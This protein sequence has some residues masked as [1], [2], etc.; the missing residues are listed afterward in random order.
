MK[1]YKRLIEEY[2]EECTASAGEEKSA[3]VSRP[4]TLTGLALALGFNSRSELLEFRGSKRDTELIENAKLRIENFN[5]EKLFEKDYARS[6]IFNLTNSYA[7]SETPEE[8]IAPTKIPAELIAAPFVDLYRDILAQGHMEYVLKGGRGSTK[9]SFAALVV[10]ERLMKNREEHAIAMRQVGATLKDS[11]YARLCWA[12]SA[13]GL[14]NEFEC[15]LMP[16]EIVRKETKQKI[17]F[18]GADDPTKLKS[19]TPSFG[20]MGTLWLEEL[21]QFA[22]EASIRNIEQSV[23]RGGEGIVIMTFNPPKSKSSWVNRFVSQPKENR[24]IHH[25][26]YLQIPPQ[27][28]GKRFIDEALYLKETNPAAYAHE[29]LGEC[30]G[31]GGLVFENVVLREI[32]DEE[33]S[34]FDRI[35]N[36]I[37]WGWYPDPFR[38]CRV[39]YCGADRR[40][41]IFDEMGGNKLP[42]AKITEMLKEKGITYQD[43]ITADSGGEG[44]KSIEDLKAAGFLIRGAIKGAGSVEYSMKWLC[45]LNE[46]VIDHKRCPRTA[47]EFTEYE[48][49]KDKNGFVIGGYPDKNNHS[50][51]AVRYAVEE[52]WRKRGA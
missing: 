30:V 49:E 18:R 11:V 25:S 12:I 13:L 16:M 47:R 22:G 15:K 31:S 52:I 17:Y 43:R 38:F 5:E 24:L 21:D 9:S 29:Y 3:K 39:S 20:H 28:L 34:R 35:Y 4:P 51:D 50:I 36:G 8:V 40:L 48:F 14:E 45:G 2:F 6:A 42:N 23:I 19:L 46:I 32:G 41:Y 10:V 1:G 33:I 7:A 26:T 27:W 37:D 44:P